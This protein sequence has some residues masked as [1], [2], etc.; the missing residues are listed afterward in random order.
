MVGFPEISM[1]E[2]F[3]WGGFGATPLT[4]RAEQQWNAVKHTSSGGFPYSEGVFED[5]TKA[6]ISQLYWNDRPVEETVREYAAFEYSPEVAA[7]VA[8]VVATLEQ[9][10]HLRWWPDELK[11]VKLTMNWF[12]SRGA[13]PQADP[14]CGR[15]LSDGPAHRRAAFSPSPKGMAWR[16]LYLRALLDAELK[17][18]GGK[19]ERPLQRRLRGVDRDLPCPECQPLR[20]PATSRRFPMTGR[21]RLR[22]ILNRQPIDRLSWTTLVDNIIRCVME[23]A[24]RATTVVMTICGWLVAMK[25][26]LIVTHVTAAALLASIW[27]RRQLLNR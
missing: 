1:H 10:H 25:K 7:D 18:N 23:T 2:T 20:P 15:G 22:A 9:N 13:R 16:Q 4:R 6:A 24:M 19:S 3:P 27:R 5:L 17:A 8:Q 14:R 11:G 26:P 12:P 21:E